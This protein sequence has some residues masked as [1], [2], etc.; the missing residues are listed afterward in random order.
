METNQ[1]TQPEA[2][3]QMTMEQLFAQTI[4]AIDFEKVTHQEVIADVLNALNTLSFRLMVA[5]AVLQKITPKNEIEEQLQP[6][7][8]EEPVS[9]PN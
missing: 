3:K 1:E 4:N 7:V 9:E 8:D 6:A 2:P 5:T